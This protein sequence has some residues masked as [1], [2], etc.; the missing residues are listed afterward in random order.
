MKMDEADHI[1]L[2]NREHSKFLLFVCLY[3]ISGSS[4]FQKIYE[5]VP[6]GKIALSHGWL[7]QCDQE[8]VLVPKAPYILDSESGIGR[9]LLRRKIKT[10]SK[11]KCSKELD[12]RDYDSEE[13]N[14]VTGMASSSQR[15]SERSPSPPGGTESNLFTLADR[16]WFFRYVRAKFEQKP[17]ISWSALTQMVARKVKA[18]RTWCRHTHLPHA[19]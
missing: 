4:Q 6:A 18:I 11:V 3:G 10:P 9:G 12:E 13:S 2:N 1:I 19:C 17:E 8:G 5:L 7:D 15:R 14:S 16:E